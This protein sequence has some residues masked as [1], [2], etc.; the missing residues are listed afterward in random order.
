MTT[1]ALGTAETEARGCG[2]AD[3]QEC[4]YGQIYKHEPAGMQREKV[5]GGR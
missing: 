2:C 1:A 3:N 5:G 4:H